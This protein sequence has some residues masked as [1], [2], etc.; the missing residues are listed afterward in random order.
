MLSVAKVDTWIFT[1]VQF[2]KGNEIYG[3]HHQKIFDNH[4]GKSLFGVKNESLG[5]TRG[6]GQFWERCTLDF[7]EEHGIT[8]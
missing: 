1:L 6:L 5:T 8:Y 7:I 2:F 4:Y 3:R